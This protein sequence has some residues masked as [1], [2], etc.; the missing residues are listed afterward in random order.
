MNAH[1]KRIQTFYKQFVS[2]GDLVFDVGANIGERIEI[3]RSLGA[4]VVSVEPHPECIQVLKKKFTGDWDVV[5]VPRAL[6]SHVGL[7]NLIT[8]ECKGISSLSDSWVKA[9]IESDR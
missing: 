2:S 5:V 1:D 3:F 9:M 8:G 4:K 6:G 7:G